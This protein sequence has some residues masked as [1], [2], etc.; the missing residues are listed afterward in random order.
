MS[1]EELLRRLNAGEFDEIAD[2]PVN[3]P[4]LTHLAIFASF[5]GLLER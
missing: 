4:H 1:G 3:H 2:D 5:L